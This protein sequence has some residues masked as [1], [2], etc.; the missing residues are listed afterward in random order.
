MSHMSAQSIDSTDQSRVTPPPS[1]KK[2]LGRLGLMVRYERQ[3]T[4]GNW[5]IRKGTIM[6]QYSSPTNAVRHVNTTTLL[7]LYYDLYMYIN[8]R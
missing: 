6:T 2:I 8:Y 4:V 7:Q 5:G 3:P 1:N